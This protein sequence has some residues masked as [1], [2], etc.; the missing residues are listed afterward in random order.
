M[1]PAHLRTAI[2]LLAL[3]AVPAFAQGDGLIVDNPGLC[4]ATSGEQELADL[5]YLTPLGI[6]RHVG[7]CRWKEPLIYTPGLEIQ[8]QAICWDGNTQ[9]DVDIDITVN[10]QGRV[11]AFANRGRTGLPDYYFPCELWGYRN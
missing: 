3:S 1:R 6:D 2:L 7:N 11:T 4:E 5:A 8:V 9:S 10:E